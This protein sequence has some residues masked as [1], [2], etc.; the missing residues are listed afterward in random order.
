MTVAHDMVCNADVCELVYPAVHCE[1][2]V[3][4]VFVL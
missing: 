3:F 1:L 2:C 4:F